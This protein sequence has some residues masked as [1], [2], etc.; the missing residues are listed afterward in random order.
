MNKKRIAGIAL[1]GMACLLASCG[2]GSSSSSG[3]PA[4]SD[5]QLGT[6]ATLS[7]D[8]HAETP[9]T[10]GGGGSGQPPANDTGSDPTASCDGSIDHCLDLAQLRIAK[11]K[12]GK[13]AAA[14][15]TFDD[16]YPSSF[17]IAD[18]FETRN[19]RASFYIIA[20]KVLNED[21][22]KWK[23]LSDKGHEIG[24]HSRARGRGR[25]GPARAEARR[26]GG[27]EQAQ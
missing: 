7:P 13:Q 27:G 6:G 9:Q 19:L 8:M 23:A 1:A 11:Y 5:T 24:N 18:M 26:G 3:D 15:Y 10:S 21:W 2:G 22:P 12:G 25:G 14:S 20:G 17:T 16:G 4:K